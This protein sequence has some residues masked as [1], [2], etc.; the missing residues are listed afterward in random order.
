[1][2][3]YQGELRRSME[4]KALSVFTDRALRQLSQNVPCSLFNTQGILDKQD[5]Y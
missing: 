4:L 2:G 3:K 5:F 1:M